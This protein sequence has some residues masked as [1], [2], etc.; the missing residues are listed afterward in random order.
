MGSGLPGIHD[1]PS[2]GNCVFEDFL[3]NRGA[4]PAFRGHI[5]RAFEYAFQI[6]NQGGMI[7]KTAAFIHL[8]REVDVASS[9]SLSSRH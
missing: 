6:K 5:D 9:A 3:P 8:H 2:Y 7:E 4:E 1:L